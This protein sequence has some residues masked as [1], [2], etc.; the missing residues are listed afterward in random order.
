MSA[1]SRPNPAGIRPGDGSSLS[2]SQVQALRFAQ[3]AVARAQLGVGAD[4]DLQFT[5]VAECEPRLT[6]GS[7]AIIL[8]NSTLGFLLLGN[9]DSNMR[10]R[11]D[12][13]VKW[14]DVTELLKVC[15]YLTSDVVARDYAKT[16]M[17]A[18][19]NLNVWRPCGPLAGAPASSGVFKY[20][21]PSQEEEDLQ[22]AARLALEVEVPPDVG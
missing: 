2:A 12:Y 8:F 13:I 21:L 15:P 3:Q 19:Y 22:R 10:R 16:A 17:M 20:N 7:P 6:L 18:S 9:E 1:Q 5:C 4:F 14:Q 11:S